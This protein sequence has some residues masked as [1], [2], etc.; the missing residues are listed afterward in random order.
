M[1]IIDRLLQR[2]FSESPSSTNTIGRME[3]NGFHY[4]FTLRNN[5]EPE[6]WELIGGNDL[7][8]TAEKIDGLIMKAL[9]YWMY[10][11]VELY[12]TPEPLPMNDK[13]SKRAAARRL[14]SPPP[15]AVR[16]AHYKETKA[17]AARKK[18]AAE[19]RANERQAAALRR[20]K[21]LATQA[22]NAERGKDQRARFAEV[23]AKWFE[24]CGDRKVAHRQAVYERNRSLRQMHEAG[25]TYRSIGEKYGLSG[26][27]V[28]QYIARSIRDMTRPAP[29]E[30]WTAIAST[31][32]TLPRGDRMKLGRPGIAKIERCIVTPW[33]KSIRLA[34]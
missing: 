25:F 14:N 23:E 21:S 34:A 11:R 28:S 13:Q 3:K 18:E 31:V 17:A 33:G 10:G 22:A 4:L 8:G 20:E 24:F 5:R 7:N 32:S 15:L 29:I 12:Y 26:T 6:H 16:L 27:C 2:G 1:K 19:R 9:G 30:D